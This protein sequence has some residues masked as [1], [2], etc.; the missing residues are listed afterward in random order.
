VQSVLLATKD[1]EALVVVL[2]DL[3]TLCTCLKLVTIGVPCVHFWAAML[4]SPSVTFTVASLNPRWITNPTLSF[5]RYFTCATKWWNQSR[6]VVPSGCGVMIGPLIMSPQP[7]RAQARTEAHSTGRVFTNCMALTRRA[8]ARVAGDPLRA[9]K[10]HD[11]LVQLQAEMDA[12]HPT[13]IS[14]NMDEL[15]QN[16]TPAIPKGRPCGSRIPSSSEPRPK[17]RLPRGNPVRIES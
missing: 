7:Q 14:G 16:P 3:S 17:K 10:L 2:P 8:F 15:L 1:A 4:E 13:T 12:G 11:S 9:K 6:V 5:P